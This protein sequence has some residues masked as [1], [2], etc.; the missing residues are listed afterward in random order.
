MEAQE[1]HLRSTQQPTRM[2]E[3]S[4]R[5]T[6]ATWHLERLASEPN[7]FKTTAGDAFRTMLCGR[8]PLPGRTNSCGQT[9]HRHSA[10]PSTTNRRAHSR[11]HHQL[12]R[13]KHSPTKVITMRSAY[14]TS[15]Q[16]TYYTKRAWQTARQHQHQEQR[17][18]TQ[19]LNSHSIQRNTKHTDGQSANY[20][21]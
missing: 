11:Q 1:S 2:A 13:Q 7:V 19:T 14:R 5:N 8:S 18:A 3:T 15:T 20:S 9:V 6:A 10:A 4:S 16:Q 17:S 21:G 12:P